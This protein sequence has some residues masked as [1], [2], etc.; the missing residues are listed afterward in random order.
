MIVTFCGHRT[1]YSYSDTLH[2]QLS[3]ILAD[4]FHK[5]QSENFPLAFYCGGYGG[6]DS[7]VSQAIDSTRVAY[8]GVKNE[9]IFVTPYITPSYKERNEYMRLHYDDILYPPIE[10]APYRLAI[11]KRNEWMVEQADLV[12]AFVIHSWGGAAHTLEFAEK[13]QKKILLLHQ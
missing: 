9:K 2:E 6:F 5:A 11:V 3:S 12:I 10:T 8:S 13:K 4:L 7:F 1:I